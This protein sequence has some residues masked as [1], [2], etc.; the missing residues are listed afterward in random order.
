MEDKA[1]RF[2]EKHGILEY[3]VQGSKMVWVEKF[4][5]E[6]TFTHV[7]DLNT[8]DEVVTKTEKAWWE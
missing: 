1:L 4:Y 6:G 5:N 2:A 7:L 3:I 8:Y